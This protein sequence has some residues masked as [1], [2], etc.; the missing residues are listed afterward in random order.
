M[1]MDYVRR[2]YGVPAKRGGRVTYTG[3][4]DGVAREGTIAGASDQYLSIRLD[5][6]QRPSRLHPTWE[7]TYHDAAPAPGPDT[8]PAP[9][10]V[11]VCA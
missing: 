3:S 10:A 8:D 9:S 2:T 6:D 5:G 4:A 11:E 7:L 1:S